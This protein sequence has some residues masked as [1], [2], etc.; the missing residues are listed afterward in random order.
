VPQ[1]EL[2]LVLLFEVPPVSDTDRANLWKDRYTVRGTEVELVSPI[3]WRMDPYDNLN[4]RFWFHAMQHLDVPLRIYERDD[5]LSALRKARDQFLDWVSA[6]PIGGERTGDYAWFDMSAGIRAA[7]LG[8][9]WRECRRHD[10]LDPEQDRA[11]T[12]SLHTHAEW[13][14]ADENY[15]RETN[16][17]LFEDAGL[18]LMGVYAAELPESEAWRELGESRFLETLERHVQFEEG[19]HK[20]QSPSY[21]FYIRDVMKLLNEQAGIGGERLAEVVRKMDV[22]AGWMVLPDGKMIPFGD[23]DLEEAPEFAREAATEEGMR[24]YPRT[25]Y[26]FV[27]R[28]GSYLGFTCC[29]HSYAHKHADE[30]SWTL[31]ENGHLIVGEAGRYGYRDEKDPARIYARASHGHN[32]LIVEDES[33]PWRD[34][35]MYGSGLL[36]AGEAY[37][38]YTIVGRNPLIEPIEH[39]RVLLYRP[40]DLVLVVDQLQAEEE[41][42]IDRRLHF[43]PELIA[44]E[45]DGTVVAKDEDGRLLA[46]LFDASEVPVEIDLARGVEQ[47]RMDGWTFPR[48]LVK[49]PSDAATLRCT[50]ASGLLI[51]GIALTPSLPERVT[52][53][54]EGDGM[55][56]EIIGEGGSSE[57]SVAQS[58]ELRVASARPAPLS[59]S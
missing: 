23:T 41:H 24:A 11:L 5:D 40:G 37:G 26:A 56:I 2:P 53:R 55:V 21:H 57:V 43:G 35:E 6:N 50:M 47:P 20:E 14:S 51:H 9:V 8:Y 39:R 15:T 42:T 33:F 13:L 31:F 19:V 1:N 17:G 49:V 54:V 22:A 48:D 34:R 32:A 10:Q 46:T 44:S 18:F 52:A 12:E 16:H 29:Y 38:W 27:R 59:S 58:T 36:S 25:G 3:D 30:L 45:S 28:N 4:W 7:F